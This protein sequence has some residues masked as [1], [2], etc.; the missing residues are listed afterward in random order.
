MADEQSCMLR[1]TGYS[2]R[3]SVR[4]GDTVSFHINAEQNES[5]QAHMVRLIHGDTSP[6]GPGYKEEDI[7]SPLNGTHQGKHQPL[8]AGSYVMVPYSEH[9][10]VESFTLCAYIFPTTP[11]TDTEGVAVGALRCAHTSFRPRR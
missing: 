5:F 9:F 4:P 1:I 10:D 8:H 3:F 11:V 2:D 7:K 6:A